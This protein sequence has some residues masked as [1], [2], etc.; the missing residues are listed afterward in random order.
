[1]AG[2]SRPVVN[3]STIGTTEVSAGV[4]DE[5]IEVLGWLLS[6]ARPAAFRF[7]EGGTALTGTI[8]IPANGSLHFMGTPLDSTAAATAPLLRLTRAEG[9][10]LVLI[11]GGP[12]TGTLVVEHV[13]DP[14]A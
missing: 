6:A 14:E 7:E 12:L 4:T 9:L 10:D 11:E 1:M 8:R 13:S 2:I 3:V 5:R